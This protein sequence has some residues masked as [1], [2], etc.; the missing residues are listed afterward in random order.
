M[1]EADKRTLA[2]I[3]KVIMDA[4][5][6]ITML[7]GTEILLSAE[8]KD[9]STT[10]YGALKRAICDAM[11]VRWIDVLSRKRG[12]EITG[13]RQLYCYFRMQYYDGK[14]EHV[15]KEIFRDHTT[16]LKSVLVIDGFIDVQ[17]ELIAP[18]VK[19]IK[20]Q[21]FNEA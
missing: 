3:D 21:L 6:T 11:K 17:D 14:C 12:D 18:A 13:A 1:I 7:C 9:L 16:V 10:P 15:G 4:Q 19:K 5:N 2:I 8:I 20:Q